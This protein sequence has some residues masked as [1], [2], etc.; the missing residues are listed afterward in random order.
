MDYGSKA[1]IASEVSKLVTSYDFTIYKYH[2]VEYQPWNKCR[3]LNSVIKHLPEGYGFVA[4][5]DMIYHPEFVQ[6]AS[7][8]QHPQK[9]VY[10]KVGFLS[11]EESVNNN[12]FNEYK[13]KFFSKPG[14]TGLTM[15]PVTPVREM[16]GFDE[17]YHF[18]GSEDTDLHLRLQS[19]GVAVD[20][21]QD[22]V[23]ML[24]QWH[25]I[26]RKSEQQSLTEELQIKGIVQLNYR[27]LQRA[28]PHRS[29]NM[30]GWGIIPSEQQIAQLRSGS[31]S[32]ITS[33]CDIID[34]FIFTELPN[35]KPGV[36]RFRITQTSQVNILKAGLNKLTG[37]KTVPHYS[38]KE[39]N[40]KLL[41]HI[42][43]FYRDLPYVYR[44]EK[45]AE[46]IVFSVLKSG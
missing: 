42:I 15:F 44:V 8:M 7:S 39:V 26:Y 24:H 40:D 10:F 27:Y 29:V 19:R 3:A 6:R 25:K 41:L 13:V 20:F 5:V 33:Q 45:N 22:E 38:L 31:I 4:D 36:H 2:Q 21:Y 30:N 43:S 46:A 9:A 1:E 17:F 18:W 14:A 35:L 28:D 37:K 34:A 32:E 11:E 16:R 23:L 12:P